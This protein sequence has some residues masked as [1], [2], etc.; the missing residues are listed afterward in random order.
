MA[1]ESETSPSTRVT[2]SLYGSLAR[3]AGSR[4]RELE[5]QGSTPTVADLRSAIAREIPELADHVSHLAVGIGTEVVKDNAP[6]D[7]SL[8]ISLLPPVSGG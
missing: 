1:T 7:P 4:E 8:E 2:I 5:I 3:L 6:L